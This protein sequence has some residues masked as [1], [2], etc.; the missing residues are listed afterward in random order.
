[1][2]LAGFL[3]VGTLPGCVRE[4]YGLRW[5]LAERAAFDARAARDAKRPGLVLFIALIY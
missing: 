5:G 4:A 1:M 2:R 3:I